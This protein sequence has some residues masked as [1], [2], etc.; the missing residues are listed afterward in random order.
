MDTIVIGLTSDNIEYREEV[1]NL[2]A[3]C[4]INNLVLNI[5][6]TKEKIVDFRT[7]KKITHSPVTIKEEVMER[8]P[9]YKFLGVTIT[10]D[11]SWG[12]NTAGIVGKVQQRLYFLRRLRRANLLQKLFQFL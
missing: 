7:T 9:S 8:V 10:E 1:Q 3:C 6:K 4:D 2:T 11:L 12:D 5:K